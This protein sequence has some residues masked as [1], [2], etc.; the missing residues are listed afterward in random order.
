MI[1]DIKQLAYFLAIAEE[2]N[3]TK[4]AERLHIAQPPLSQQ[5]KLL[6]EELGVVLMERSTRKIQITDA[7]R[8][9]QN[10]AKQIIE[11]MEKNNKGIQ[12]FERGT[13]RDTFHRHNLFS[14]S[15]I[16]AS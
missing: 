8:L 14:G 16:T 2:G 12:R 15:S 6:E 9:L 3:I 5:L 1:L 11:L 7:G 4:A 10:R 13:S